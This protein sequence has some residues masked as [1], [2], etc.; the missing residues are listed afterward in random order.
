MANRSAAGFGKVMSVTCLPASSAPAPA[1]MRPAGDIALNHSLQLLALWSC[2]R[3]VSVVQAQRQIHIGALLHLSRKRSGG[4]LRWRVIERRRHQPLFKPWS[5]HAVPMVRTEGPQQRP[6]SV[7][8]PVA[9]DTARAISILASLLWAAGITRARQRRLELALDHCLDELAH[10]IAQPG[11]NRIKPIVENMD[12]RL[13]FRLQSHRLR[14]IVGHGVVSTG[15]RTP[16]LFGFQSPGDYATFNSNRTPDGT[17]SYC[18]SHSLDRVVCCPLGPIS[19][20]PR[21]EVR[22]EHRFEDELERTLH[23]S[24]PDRRDR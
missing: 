19:I 20:R 24:V 3:R 17:L 8:V 6:Q 9:S 14:A 10:P 22:L 2:G 7:A 13:G 15:A 12:R 11:F 21:L 18:F 23:H 5:C 4:L 16:A 1:P